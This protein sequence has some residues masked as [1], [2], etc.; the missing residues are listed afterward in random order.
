MGGFKAEAGII[1]DFSEAIGDL[2]VDANAART[3]A[4]DHLDIAGSDARIFATVAGAAADARAV[5]SEN[6][7]RLAQI[8]SA[9]ATELDKAAL[10]YD[11]TDRAEAARIDATYE[12]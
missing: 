11:D 7:R 4:E 6:Y 1:Q 10:M 8:Q 12:G 9:A 3:Y 2:V 5:L